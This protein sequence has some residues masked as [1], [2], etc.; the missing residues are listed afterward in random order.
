MKQQHKS[1]VAIFEAARFSTHVSDPARMQAE[2]HILALRFARL[3]DRLTRKDSEKI[4]TALAG[5]QLIY[6]AAGAQSKVRQHLTNDCSTHVDHYL[7]LHELLQ[8]RLAKISSLAPGVGQVP[9]TV[10]D[11]DDFS[12]LTKSICILLARNEKGISFREARAKD[13]RHMVNNLDISSIEKY[14]EAAQKHDWLLWDDLT[15]IES[16]IG[17]NLGTEG[18][19]DARVKQSSIHFGRENTGSQRGV[20]HG[21]IYDSHFPLG[22]G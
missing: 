2:L 19:P 4:S 21:G 14:K 16:D 15:T 7:P 22:M 20:V 12:A 18:K 1:P 3:I 10:F 11:N 5:L 13:A 17:R 9:F 6:K 8:E